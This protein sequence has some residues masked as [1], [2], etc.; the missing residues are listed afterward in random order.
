M[1][2][3]IPN[4]SVHARSRAM[5]PVCTASNNDDLLLEIYMATHE[6]CKFGVPAVKLKFIS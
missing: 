5:Q 6:R 1:D 2:T 4:T 3:L